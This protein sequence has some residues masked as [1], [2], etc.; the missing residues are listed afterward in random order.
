MVENVRETVDEIAVQPAPIDLNNPD[1]YINREISLLKFHQRVLEEAM[2]ETVPLMERVKFL[3]IF[4]N[5]MDEFFM[6]RVAGLWGQVQA[7]VVDLPADGMTAQE[8]LDAIRTHSLDM[9]NLQRKT[10]HEQVLPA[11][12]EH[13]IR[14]LEIDDLTNKQRKA[15]NKY[16]MT[17][18][19]P[20]LT[21]LGVDPGRPFPFIS[22]LSLNLAV[23]LEDSHGHQKFAR[24]KVPTGVLPRL[25][26][27][28][29]VMEHFDRDFTGIEN[30]FLYL[31]DIIAAN[32]E[33]LFSGMKILEA[34]P[35]RLARN[36][37]I[38][39]AEEEASDLLETIESGVQMRRFGNIT[40]LS[41]DQAMPEKLRKQLIEYMN[42][43]KSTVYEIAKPLGMADL[44]GLYAQADAPT[45]KDPGFAPRRPVRLAP[46]N[47]LF[48]VVRERDVLMYHPYDS[49]TPVVDFIQ[50]AATDPQVLA[51]K[52]TLYRLG[53]DSP[54]VDAL[55]EAR[56]Q[57]KQVAALVELKARFDEE[58]NIGWAR[59]LE[60]EG[61]HV[62]YGFK[63]LKTH[64]KVV[65]VVRQESDGLRRYVHFG[66]GNYNPITARIYTDI[67]L[68]TC[69][70]DLAD[71]AT[72][73]FNRL[74]GFAPDTAYKKLLV[75]PEYL[76]N[77]IYDLIDREIEH[78]R[79]GRPT[80]LVFKMNALVDR[81]MIRKLY[82]ASMAGIPIQ[83]IVRGICCL[84]PGIPGVSEN[85]TVRSI[86]GRFLEHA[87]IYYFR[88]GG[89]EE[90][91]LGSADLMP[92]NLDRRVETVFPVE[93]RALKIEIRDV[94]LQK[95]LEDNIKTRLLQPDGSYIRRQPVGKEKSTGQPA[96][97]RRADAASAIIDSE[98][99]IMTDSNALVK[100]AISAHKANDKAKA[101]ELLMKAVDLDDQN[102]QAWMWLSTVVDSLNEQ[103]ICLDNVVK[104]NPNNERAQKALAAITEK[105]GQSGVAP[106][107][108]PDASSAPPDPDNPWASA[109][110]SSDP[111]SALDQSPTAHGSGAAGDPT[112]EEQYDSWIDNL[113]ISG[114]SET[115]PP[116]PAAPPPPSPEPAADDPWADLGSPTQ[117][118]PPAQT[119]PFA[120]SSSQPADPWAQTSN[121][122]PDSADQPDDPWGAVTSSS[123]GSNPFSTEAASSDPWGT[124]TGVDPWATPPSGQDAPPASHPPEPTQQEAAIPSPA[125]PEPEEE[126]P[127]TG[128]QFDEDSEPV[129]TSFDF[130][131]ADA[132][133]TGEFDFSEDDLQA[134]PFGDDD[135]MVGFDPFV[136]AGAS[137]AIE[138]SGY[139][140]LIPEELRVSGGGSPSRENNLADSRSGFA[141]SGCRRR[142]IR[143]ITK[144]PELSP[145]RFPSIFQV[146]K[147]ETG[148]LT[149]E[150]GFVGLLPGDIQIVAPKVTI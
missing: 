45:L 138:G 87:R 117:S 51:I 115:P 10:F 69:R 39:I 94:I 129:Y 148:F 34:Y 83:L 109:D 139:L 49:F 8:Q 131:E 22:N 134:D 78:Q 81:R 64:S 89:N 132:I 104:I 6:T 88:N 4:S 114:T 72:Q 123:S 15:V 111:F 65:L 76:R 58:N 133:D 140:P 108:T 27:L 95:Q 7:G 142:V 90:V 3:A 17:E 43:P 122:S 68:L 150:V 73:L 137:P 110:L 23:T 128:F 71:D 24:V 113:G 126:R 63:G 50:A 55:M 82:K 80:G 136:D 121:A 112:T 67:A 29:T 40:R 41:I 107:P 66:T 36:A 30:T 100:Q 147:L 59:A 14:I 97:V 70:E 37:D 21:P 54:I 102:E 146:A 145:A 31:E 62:I 101:K 38:D 56:A 125:Q 46:G 9:M 127:T 130:E 33:G 96:V 25:V 18:I 1:L 99:I 91:Y 135:D 13:G 5:N 11:L 116:A 143:G 47:D 144:R 119:N 60:A 149:Q 42:V 19:F 16:F 106:P 77:A 32:L 79:A 53:K 85:I 26:T 57:D 75:A 120:E 93:S 105:L 118:A 92:R 124:M 74:T 48:A 103:Q 84:R 44:F 52:C 61:V 141:Q 86:V 2:D 20:V 98:G 12:G 28:R 35:F